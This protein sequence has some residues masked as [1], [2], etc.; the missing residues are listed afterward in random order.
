[1]TLLGKGIPAVPGR[2]RGVVRCTSEEVVKN[3]GGIL[4]R[5]LTT[6]DDIMGMEMADG[7]LTVIGGKMSHA[8]VVAR[9]WNKPCVVG[10]GESLRVYDDEVLIKETDLTNKTIEID[11]GTGE[12]W[13]VE[14]TT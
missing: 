6:P 11:G 2:V 1:M 5:E 12:V 3:G 8:A 4:V 13:L 7:I 14:G 10:F 9:G